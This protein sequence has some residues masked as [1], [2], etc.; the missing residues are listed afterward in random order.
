MIINAEKIKTNGVS[1]F[2]VIL[3]T[4]DEVIISFRGENRYVIIEIER[5]FYLEDFVNKTACRKD[6]PPFIPKKFTDTMKERE[7]KYETKIDEMA[8]KMRTTKKSINANDIK[9]NGIS[10]LDSFLE[11]DDTVIIN[12]SGKSKYIALK[13]NK[14]K[15][16]LTTEQDYMYKEAVSTDKNSEIKLDE[17]DEIDKFLKSIL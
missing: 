5:Y 7:A 2:K 6:H 8:K 1:L 16:L 14:Y 12:V 13:I 10:I 11:I 15:K 9:T 4:Y 17:D 3:K